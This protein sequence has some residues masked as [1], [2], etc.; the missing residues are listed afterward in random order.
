MPQPGNYP[1][2]PDILYL[3]QGF[4]TFKYVGWLHVS[5]VVPCWG[6]LPPWAPSPLCSHRRHTRGPR[7]GCY[8]QQCYSVTVLHSTML[9]CNR[10]QCC[11]TEEHLHCA[12]QQ[13]APRGQPTAHR[14]LF[15][16]RKSVTPLF[17]EFPII[18]S[19]Q[20]IPIPLPH[21]ESVFEVNC[22]A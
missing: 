19:T 20:P 3:M 14:G 6:V 13:L 7:V 12:G 16:D 8:T 11:N 18:D 5:S 10:Q 21:S 15:M 9:H 1:S 17:W 22:K 4:E 2:N